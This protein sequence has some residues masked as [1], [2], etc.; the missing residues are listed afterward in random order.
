MKRV[1]E[2]I[3][4]GI[5]ASRDMVVSQS[6]EKDNPSIPITG[7]VK[8]DKEKRAEVWNRYQQLDP[9]GRAEFV[10]RGLSVENPIPT[11]GEV[12]SEQARF[13]QT[14]LDTYGVSEEVLLNAI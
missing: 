8:I 6:R 1:A 11:S 5:M 10:R 4:R 2:E 9:G 12:K 14:M 3:K 7:P 13:E